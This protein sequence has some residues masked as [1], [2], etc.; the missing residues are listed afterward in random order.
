MESIRSAI[1]G[2]SAHLE[3]A[4]AVPVTSEVVIS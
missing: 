2:A 4:R 1:E 3:I